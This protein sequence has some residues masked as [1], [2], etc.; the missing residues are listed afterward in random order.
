[1]RN[2]IRP[3][4]PSKSKCVFSCICATS[5]KKLSSYFPYLLQFNLGV[6]QTIYISQGIFISFEWI[7]SEELYFSLPKLNGKKRSMVSAQSQ[8]K[9][10]ESGLCSL[11][12]CWT[13]RNPAFINQRLHTAS[14][15]FGLAAGGWWVRHFSRAAAPSAWNCEPYALYTSSTY[16]LAHDSAALGRLSRWDYVGLHSPHSTNYTPSMIAAKYRQKLKNTKKS[17]LCQSL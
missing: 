7:I 15:L 5:Y 1:M 16:V 12:S 17:L 8:I 14:R 11:H 6:K 10:E 13:W 2:S 9:F 3:L 4:P